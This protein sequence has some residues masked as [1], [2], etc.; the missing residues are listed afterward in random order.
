[1]FNGD[2]DQLTHLLYSASVSPYLQKLSTSWK[3]YWLNL[4]T[5]ELMRFPLCISEEIPLTAS[6]DASID[7]NLKEP[8]DN[9]NLHWYLLGRD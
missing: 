4:L 2:S 9:Q 5:D 6:Y 8:A 3:L 1:M 7:V